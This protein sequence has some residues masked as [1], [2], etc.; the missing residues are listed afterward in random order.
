MSWRDNLQQASFRG[1]PFE[2][3]AATTGVGRRTEMHVYAN[4]QTGAGK[5]YQDYVWAKDLGAEPD[6]FT[7]EGYVI[8]NI[9]NN[10]DHFPERDNLI[11]ALKTQGPGILVHPS[12]KEPMEVS[13]DGK[14]TIT[15]SYT[16]E[17]GIARFVMNFV[18]YN[19]PIFTQLD[20]D[21]VE[22]V[23]QSVLD[24]V[25]A[26]LDNF[27]NLM[28]TAGAFLGSLTAPLLTTIGKMQNAIASTKGAIAST[29]S[30]AIGTISNVLTLIDSSLNSPCDLIETIKDGAD[31]CLG[32]V[33]LAGE[34]VQGG[35]IGGCSGETRGD[36]ITMDGDEI[37]ELLGMSVAKNMADNADYEASSL[38]SIPD[39]QSDNLDLA[40]VSTQ[41]LMIGNAI[42]IAIRIDYSSQEKMEEMLESI[43]NS[44]DNL[45][46]RIG[47]LGDD[48]DAV[49]L[50][51]SVSDM[52]AVFVNSMYEK[53]TGLTK[54]IAYEVPPGVMS[55]LELAYNQY[56][57][58]DRCSEIF[59]RNP[60]LVKH[61]GFLPSGEEINILDE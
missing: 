4:T 59:D 44:L 26:A 41:S 58:V 3:N 56:E 20:T 8:Q 45:I 6:S 51:E 9:T 33:G 37:P 5:K 17:G 38:G 24:M 53:N 42:K 7:I 60:D 2:V 46:T 1:I 43:M 40:T 29:I 19:K 57:N 16:A 21:Y 48:V 36:I 27:T 50:Y 14:A 47:S 23:D 34:I 35:V 10:F 52:R 54:E 15:E 31:A 49:M 12:F 18:Q 39:E 30:S 55:T 32:L 22:A 25:N 28:N 11:K 61:P 13:L